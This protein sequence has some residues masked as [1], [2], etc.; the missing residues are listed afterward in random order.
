MTSYVENDRLNFLY[1]KHVHFDV[2]FDCKLELIN[3]VQHRLNFSSLRGRYR[4]L[5]M[6]NE[7]FN[8]F[9]QKLPYLK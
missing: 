8:N 6:V 4:S 1:L 5:P 3:T 9:S 7:G 2:R